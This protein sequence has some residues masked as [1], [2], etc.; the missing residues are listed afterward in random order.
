M[1]QLFYY[2]AFTQIKW[3]QFEKINVP[4]VYC[5]IIYSNSQDMEA[6]Q[7]SINKWM[8]KEKVVYLSICMCVCV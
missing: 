8:D 6:V 7:A 2:W 4:Y 1:I 3:K 5:S